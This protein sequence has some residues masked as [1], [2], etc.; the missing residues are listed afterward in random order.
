[1]CVDTTTGRMHGDGLP[2]S[3]PLTCSSSQL[4]SQSLVDVAI[5]LL[6]LQEP[7]TVE[8]IQWAPSECGRAK[9]RSALWRMSVPSQVIDVCSCRSCYATHKYSQTFVILAPLYESTRH[10]SHKAADDFL[11]NTSKAL[12]LG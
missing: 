2:S 10:S 1:M 9:L 4:R 8:Y 7:H 12:E 11:H 3:A 6:A 5:D